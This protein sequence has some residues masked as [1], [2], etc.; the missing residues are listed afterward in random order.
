M[1][2]TPSQRLAAIAQ[3][4][5]ELQTLADA[6]DNVP[7]LIGLAALMREIGRLQL[8]LA[9]AV[10]DLAICDDLETWFTD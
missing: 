9:E 7:A 6:T 2:D 4:I 10:N 8:R 3:E 5:A 1:T